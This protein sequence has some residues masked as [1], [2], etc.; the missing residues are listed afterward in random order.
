MAQ[1]RVD[2]VE[3]L[4]SVEQDYFHGAPQTVLKFL[5][6]SVLYGPAGLTDNTYA[7][8]EL[9]E[10]FKER[11]AAVLADLLLVQGGLNGWQ[12]TPLHD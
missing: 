2:E 12:K 10:N 7:E 4:I 1:I 9:T 3:G 5:G 8:E 6:V 11:I